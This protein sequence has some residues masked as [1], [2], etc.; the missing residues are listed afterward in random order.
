MGY[1][2]ASIPRLAKVV[3]K[4]WLFRLEETVKNPNRHTGCRRYLRDLPT[5][6]REW[7][8]IFWIPDQVRNYGLNAEIAG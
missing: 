2:S 1:S 6:N 5:G 7:A 4:P 3:P 8:R